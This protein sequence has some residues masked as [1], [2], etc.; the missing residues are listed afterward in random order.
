MAKRNRIPKT[1]WWNQSL[2]RVHH[3]STNGR[4]APPKL[5]LVKNPSEGTLQQCINAEFCAYIMVVLA[6]AK[7]APTGAIG[8]AISALI[9]RPVS[10]SVAWEWLL[11]KFS[12]L[13][14]RDRYRLSLDFSQGFNC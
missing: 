7:K 12:G 9:G 13:S 1:I 4:S 6:R 10:E 11:D 5:E 3:R 8:P 2:F 14:P